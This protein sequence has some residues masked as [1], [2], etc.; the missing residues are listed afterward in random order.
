MAQGSQAFRLGGGGGGGGGGG[1]A[2][3][4]GWGYMRALRWVH[5]ILVAAVSDEVRGRAA[6]LGEPERGALLPGYGTVRGAAGRAAERG[7]PVPEVRLSYGRSSLP[8]QVPPGTDVI[9]PRLHP[10]LADPVAAVR[11]A[12]GA[13][14]GCS[15]LADLA[16]G[17]RTAGISICD[18]T[19]PYPLRL[20]LPSVLEDLAG[21][22]VT[23]FVATGSHRVCTAAEMEEMLGSEIL[24]AVEVVQHDGRLPDRHRLLGTQPDSGAPVELEADY[25]DQDLRLSL[26]MVEPHFFAGFSGGPKMVAP[27]LASLETI[28]DLHSPA[29]VA[30]PRADWG[31]LAGN[32]VHDAIRNAAALAAV[33]L[34]VE[35]TQNRQR[36]VTGVWAGVPAIAHRA[37]CLAVQDGV[38][39]RAEAPYDVVV[40]TNGGYPLDQNL[41]QAVKGMSAAAQVVKPGGVILVAAECSDG[42][43]GHG[44]YRATLGAYAGPAEF[45]AAVPGL[46]PAPDLW[47]V[48]VQAKIQ[49]RARVLLHADGLTDDEVREA[50]LEPAGEV[51]EALDRLLQEAGPGARAAVLPGGPHVIPYLAG[52]HR[53]E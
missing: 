34:S 14:L 45:L 39:H 9:E 4:V 27:G 32:P 24:G 13:P 2:A 7:S 49:A 41:Y 29:R 17:R 3:E 1:T 30:D 12:L 35:V 15:P 37:A 22:Q 44:D 40:T 48:L 33:H 46:A 6:G 8:I 5:P 51:T 36:E 52:G 20:I 28:L 50:W 25:L 10:G 11:E 23:L 26:G 31:V 21:L 42:F 43:P 53:G 18:V 47:Q 38:M 16:R 19:R